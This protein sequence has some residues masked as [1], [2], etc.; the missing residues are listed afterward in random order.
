MKALIVALLFAVPSLASAVT[1]ITCVPA[2]DTD[3][4]VQV[5]FN[6]DINPLIPFIGVYEF[7]AALKITQKNS[8]YAYQI[9]LRMSPEENYQSDKVRGDAENVYLK[10]YPQ[11]K[12]GQFS[13]YTGQ[14]FV[15]DLNVR[16]YFNF[17]DLGSEPGLTCK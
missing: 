9:N 2:R 4:R 16:A 3:F 8:R 15:N 13:H 10:L 6:R 7:G 1:S 17:M 12:N 14:L 5:N 11:Q